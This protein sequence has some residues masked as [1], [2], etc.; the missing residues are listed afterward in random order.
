MPRQRIGHT[1]GVGMAITHRRAR[2]VVAHVF[3]QRF[4]VDPVIQQMRGKTVP[5]H[6]RRGGRIKAQPPAGFSHGL[7]HLP[8]RHP[9]A[10]D[11]PRARMRAGCVLW[12]N[13]RPMPGPGQLWIFS[14]Q[15]MINLNRDSVVGIL[16]KLLMRH[17]Q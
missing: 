14:A 13:P 16:F 9:V 10:H 17:H 2:I 3:L 15:T 12:K 1:L 5:Q 11:L 8:M 6:M 7:L 4:D